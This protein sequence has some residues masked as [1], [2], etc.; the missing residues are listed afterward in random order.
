MTQDSLTGTSTYD[1]TASVSN[2][3]QGP[4]NGVLLKMEGITKSFFGV[5]VLKEVD[6]DLESGEVHVLLGAFSE[7]IVQR[8]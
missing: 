4:D 6:F 5:K 2:G 1:A 3:K 8:L 7:E